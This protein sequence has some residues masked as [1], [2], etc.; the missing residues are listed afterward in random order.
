LYVGDDN[1]AV[2]GT[3]RMLLEKQVN[4]N[5]VNTMKDW[6]DIKVLIITSGG[7][8]AEGV[9]KISSF[10][11]GGGKVLV[12]GEG[13]FEE[14]KPVIDIGASYL[15]GPSY[16]VDYT[17]AGELISEG[18]VSSPFLNYSP[19]IRIKPEEG[20][21]ILASIREPFFS[22]TIDHYCSHKNT[23]YTMEDASHPAVIRKGD[24]IYMAHDLDRQYHAEGARLHRDL[25][26]N[27]LGLLRKNP[28]VSTSMPSAGRLNLLHQPEHSRYVVHLLYASPIQRGA[29][30]VIEDLIPLFNT[31][32]TLDLEKT[33]RKAYLVPS[34]EQIKLRKEGTNF[35]LTVPEFTCHTGIVLEYE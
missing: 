25:F 34:G 9:E 21:E 35:K 24:V 11:K 18:I 22:R 29:V 4:F 30:S 3:V 14:G 10:I 7:V 13:I 1:T 20:T 2:E 15:G 31:P 28:M 23:P 19:A 33:I 6:S 12:M 26:I 16:D 32:L 5:V 8:H 17:L 27:A